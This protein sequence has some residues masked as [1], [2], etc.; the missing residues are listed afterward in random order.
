MSDYHDLNMLKPMENNMAEDY[1]VNRSVNNLEISKLAR[2]NQST[3][4][5]EPKKSRDTEEEVNRTNPFKA[6]Y[7]GIAPTKTP[8]NNRKTKLD[9]SILNKTSQHL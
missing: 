1:K 7:I 6:N 5:V 8:L 3:D 9:D 4:F 2:L